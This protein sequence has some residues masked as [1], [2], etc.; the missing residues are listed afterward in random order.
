MASAGLCFTGPLLVYFRPIAL[1]G[2]AG[3][4]GKTSI[5]LTVLLHK[6]IK[7]RFGED[8]RFIRYDQFPASCARFL[9][10]LSEVIGAGVKNPKDLTPLRSLLSSK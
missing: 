9:A 8:H 2:V 7:E 6:R 3:G 10:R 1:I 5:T 4:I